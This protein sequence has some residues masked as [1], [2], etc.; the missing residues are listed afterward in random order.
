[1]CI[2]DRDGNAELPAFKPSSDAHFEEVLSAYTSEEGKICKDDF[3][4]LSAAMRMDCLGQVYSLETHAL[5]RLKDLSEAFEE[6]E[7]LTEHTVSQML[8]PL[9][10]EATLRKIVV[11]VVQT[12]S[13]GGTFDRFAG[14]VATCKCPDQPYI[15]EEME[16]AVEEIEFTSAAMHTC[17]ANEQQLLHWADIKAQTEW[18]RINRANGVEVWEFIG[19][20][21]KGANVAVLGRVLIAAPV[22]VVLQAIERSDLR[23]DT[24]VDKVSEIEWGDTGSPR[25]RGEPTRSPMS[26]EW[27]GVKL[28]VISKRD[29]C[30]CTYQ[31]HFPDGSVIVSE[32]SMEVPAYVPFADKLAPRSGYE[33]AKVLTGGWHICS[34]PNTP[35]ASVG[36]W[37]NVSN[38]G[39]HLPQM[40][41]N[42]GWSKSKA[43]D[44]VAATKVLAEQMMADQKAAEK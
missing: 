20:M 38:P 35:G 10:T 5:L 23:K 25:P 44:N 1:M 42:T 29:F 18:K 36:T 40:L 27:V 12:V 17:L 6:A 3:F 24:S 28:P 34:A 37:V 14:V 13:P 31:A 15:V 21:P 30:T 41:L 2:R 43:V 16:R 11:Q 39:G 8:S 9:C 32:V 26:L 4:S 7:Q 33:R 22:E 19:D